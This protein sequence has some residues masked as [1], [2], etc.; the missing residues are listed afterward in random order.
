MKPS[1]H[2]ALACAAL[3][4]AMACSPAHASTEQPRDSGVG[5]ARTDNRYCK[6]PH[7]FAAG[8]TRAEPQASP[9]AAGR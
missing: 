9:S 5:C 1:L 4:A 2:N 3:F 7:D 8:D 6:A